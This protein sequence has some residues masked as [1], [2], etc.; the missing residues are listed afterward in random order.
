VILLQSWLSQ[1]LENI[2]TEKMSE[3]ERYELTQTVYQ[4]AMKE[5]I[6]QVHIECKERGRLV[7]QIWN[8]SISMKNNDQ[9]KVGM[10]SSI[11]YFSEIPRTFIRI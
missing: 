2:Q 1:Q 8:D 6:K 3:K 5:V 10:Y 11:Y 9:S 4:I 7:N